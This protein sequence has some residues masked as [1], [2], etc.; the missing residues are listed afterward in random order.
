MGSSSHIRSL[1]S[2]K[3]ALRT[4]KQSAAQKKKYSK[5]AALTAVKNKSV[6]SQKVDALT[7]EIAELKVKL[8][9][10][11]RKRERKIRQYKLLR[12]TARR[13]RHIAVAKLLVK[14]CDD[15]KGVSSC[16]GAMLS[17]VP[18]TKDENLVLMR[19]VVRP[20]LVASLGMNGLLPAGGAK[21]LSTA[22][23]ADIAVGLE[24]PMR[25]RSVLKKILVRGGYTSPAISHTH[26]EF[27]R[28]LKDAAP[29][30]SP[31]LYEGQRKGVEVELGE[32]LKSAL[33]VK[34]LKAALR[35]RAYANSE[36][37]TLHIR[38][39]CDGF[40][41][42]AVGGNMCLRSVS[43]LEWGQLC[44][45]PKYC[46]VQGL[47]QGS[48]KR[49]VLTY[50]A[51]GQNKSIAELEEYGLKLEDG[52]HYNIVCLFVSDL[53][54][55]TI[56]ANC[57]GQNSLYPCV[58][59]KVTKDQR[60]VDEGALSALLGPVDG[61]TFNKQWWETKERAVVEAAAPVDATLV[62]G[63][64]DV[65]NKKKGKMLSKAATALIA[66]QGG[67]GLREL[68]ALKKGGKE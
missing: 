64:S 65:L 32:L 37:P 67:G 23:M 40:R 26:T 53:K 54:G 19:D 8:G 36:R 57:L 42:T 31:L 22:L 48:E 45:S 13:T 7:L 62:E 2:A 44:L 59:T 20:Q 56:D 12:P 17:A 39:A 9:R 15:A 43:I 3:R 35:L 10:A 18:Q 29:P 46:L 1:F 60:W 51:S 68:K 14:V 11:E 25:K 21:S 4:R 41:E 47:I 52:T 27:D 66:E 38:L 63:F 28:R 24:L 61:S 34:E 6:L 33:E 16:L 30:A 5:Q 55:H 50:T 58:W 49:A